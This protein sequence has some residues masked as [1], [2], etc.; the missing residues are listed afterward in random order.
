[1][2]KTV[3]DAANII[4]DE[5]EKSQQEL[6]LILANK[7]FHPK[8][9]FVMCFPEELSSIIDTAGLNLTSRP[10]R[11][12]GLKLYHLSQTFLLLL[13]LAVLGVVRLFCRLL[14]LWLFYYC[15]WVLP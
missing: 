6:N 5:A 13:M 12:R 2:K 9:E 11:T 1:M 4:E 8:Q 3:K 15:F 10:S 14:H 7:K